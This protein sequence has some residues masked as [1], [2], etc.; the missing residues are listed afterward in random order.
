V[1]FRV[2]VFLHSPK[3]CQVPAGCTLL[4]LAQKNGVQIL[5]GCPHGLCGTCATRVLSGTVQMDVEA[6]LVAEQ[7]NAGYTLPCVGRTSRAV[8]VAA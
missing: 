4:D 1:R 5:Y 8:V 6:G 7:K 3:V 2:V